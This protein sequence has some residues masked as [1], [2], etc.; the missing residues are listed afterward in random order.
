M[1]DKT[2]RILTPEEQLLF[3]TIPDNL[4]AQEMAHYY[5]LSS[6]DKDFI[7]QHRGEGNRLGVALQLCTL[8]FPGCYLMQMTSISE[9]LIIYVADQ[10]GLSPRAW[11]DYG[12]RQL[13]ASDHFQAICQRYGY[14]LFANDDTMPLIGYLL[15]LAMENDEALYLVDTV[16]DWLRGQKIVAPTILTIEKLVW[17]VQRMARR[18]VYHRIT[19]GLSPEQEAILESTLVVDADKR[20]KTARFWLRIP[21]KKP[22]SESM[23]HLVERIEFLN[24]LQLPPRPDNIALARFRQL[25]QRGRRYQPQALSN[26]K[27]PRERHTLLIAYLNDLHQELIDQLVDMFDRWLTNLMCKGRNKQRHHL[28]RN[29]AQLNRHLNTLTQAAEGLLNAKEQEQAIEAVFAIVKEEVLAET[30][31]SV[32]T[33]SRLADM[34]FRDLVENT[35]VRRRKAMLSMA[36]LLSFQ[37]TQ[38]TNAALEALKHTLHLLDEHNKR[39][40]GDVV[41]APLDHLKRKRWKRHAL[42]DEGINPNYYELAAFD[43]L[44]DGLRSGDIAVVGSHRYQAFADCLLPDTQWTTLKEQERTRLAVPRHISTNASSK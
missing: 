26:L 23:Y 37:P 22:S 20:G 14:R 41:T 9:R 19:H 7:Y 38:E 16:M 12:H 42:T 27:N 25:A 36:R 3:T 15:A 44:Q 4:S 6:E 13:T 43:R 1:S 35:F 18:R 39:V 10:L 29:I 24:E 5:T 30:I 11:A 17:H 2:P 32:T 8:R 31:A 34:D 33:Y 40:Q 21:A 28:H